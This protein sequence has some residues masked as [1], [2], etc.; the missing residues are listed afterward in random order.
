MS[1]FMCISLRHK[2]NIYMKYIV[3]IYYLSVKK[4]HE[5]CSKIILLLTFNVFNVFVIVK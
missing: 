3:Y 1:V 5:L 4:T 2:Y